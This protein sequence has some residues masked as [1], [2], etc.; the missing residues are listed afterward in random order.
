MT[1]SEIAH[2]DVDVHQV[3]APVGNGFARQAEVA[4]DIVNAGIVRVAVDRDFEERGVLIGRAPRRQ[5]PGV[6]TQGVVM[7]VRA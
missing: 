7:G 3:Q 5:Q 6:L 2:R 4:D 1:A